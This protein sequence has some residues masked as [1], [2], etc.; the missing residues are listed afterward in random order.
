MK[1]II[2][3]TALVFTMAIVI[4]TLFACTVNSSKGTVVAETSVAAVDAYAARGFAAPTSYKVTMNDA[5][6]AY[7][8]EESM[9]V[10]TQKITKTVDL[11]AE[12]K[13]FDESLTWVREHVAKYNGIIDSSY[14]DTGSIDD[15]NYRKNAY[16]SIRVPA[17]SLDSFLNDV[18][19]TLNVTFRNENTRDIT[20]E[21]DD[22]EGRIKTLKIE[23]DK[24]NE[25][26]EKAKNVEDMINIE[27]K[28]SDVRRELENLSKKLGRLDKQV[29]YSTVNMN[30]AEVKEL[31]ELT[32]SDDYSRENIIKLIKKNF[33]DTKMFF[34]SLFVYLITHL[35]AIISGLVILLVI[36]IIIAICRALSGDKDVQVDNSKTEKSEKDV[37]VDDSDDVEVEFYEDVDN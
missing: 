4:L 29:N 3:K 36:L 18:G 5:I 2:K 34:V 14:V 33:E 20:E 11:S 26:M 30:I 31:S 32:P 21:Y 12:T 13:E 10:S 27:S 19:G 16:F 25:L 6:G 1:K 17:E 9:D 28:L 37:N 7:S 24:L 35:P 15:T 8:T 22:T 23:E